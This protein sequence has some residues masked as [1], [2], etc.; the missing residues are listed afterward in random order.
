MQISFFD[1]KTK[2]RYNRTQHG[3]MSTK[4]KRKLERPLSGKKWIH[5]V[6]KSDKAK[7]AL[8]LL[9]PK[10]E[11]GVERIVKSKA[12]KFGVV[13]G[14][15]ANVGSHLHLKIKVTTRENFQKFLKAITNLIARFV[16]GARK[17]KPFGRFWRDLAFTRV[18]KSYREEINLRGYFIANRLE[19]KKSY[20]AREKFLGKFNDW[21]YRG[22]GDLVDYS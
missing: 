15:Y 3:G 1:K 22:G 2:K 20:A 10:N 11:I 6:L 7:G 17:G 4:G 19:G 8:S 16:T 5:L 14:D 9:T 21:V 12:R 18:L 13:I